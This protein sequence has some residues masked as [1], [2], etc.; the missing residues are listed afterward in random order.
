MALLFLLLFSS[1]TFGAQRRK[2]LRKPRS[3]HFQGLKSI[4]YHKRSFSPFGASLKKWR[5]GA[6][7]KWGG[8]TD[9][10]LN[11]SAIFQPISM[12]HTTKMTGLQCPNLPCINRHATCPFSYSPVLPSDWQTYFWRCSTQQSTNKRSYL[13]YQVPPLPLSLPHP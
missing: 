5:R 13:G 3:S 7:P 6:S 12:F 9:F 1:P 4:T 8:K 11:N 10:R 2:N